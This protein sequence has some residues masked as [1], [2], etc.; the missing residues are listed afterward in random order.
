MVGALLVSGGLMHTAAPLTSFAQLKP[1]TYV[2]I[3]PIVKEGHPVKGSIEKAV[4]TVGNLSNTVPPPNVHYLAFMRVFNS[5]DQLVCHSEA[6]Y[7]SL[8]PL[9]G[10]KAL[11]FQV[12]YPSSVTQ[13]GPGQ[14]APPKD[15]AKGVK[16]AEVGRVP[17]HVR[18]RIVANVNPTQ[19]CPSVDSNCSNNSQTRT[20]QFSAGGTPSCMKLQ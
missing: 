4:V 14:A 6:S 20:L 19:P 5:A 12:V 11:Q 7:G 3:S 16:P 17:S 1:D 2:S 13:L 8:P 10:M 18:Y 15:P 9:D